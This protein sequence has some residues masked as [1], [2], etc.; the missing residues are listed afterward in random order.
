MDGL[1]YRA[2]YQAEWR[3]YG[4]GFRAHGSGATW[5]QAPFLPPILL[6]FAHFG[7]TLAEMVL[8]LLFRV[9]APLLFALLSLVLGP[10]LQR[11]AIRANQL[12]T[13]AL[14]AISRAREKLEQPRPER[15]R[16]A[17]SERPPSRMHVPEDEN[18]ER[19][20]ATEV[21]PTPEP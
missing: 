1:C 19:P 16:V 12:G 6:V 10:R 3:A 9:A 13:T 21:R 7:L 5:D 15:L 11:A 18:A 17:N 14:T 4:H 2:A 8:A 20:P